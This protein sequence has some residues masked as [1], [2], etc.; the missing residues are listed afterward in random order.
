MTA[1]KPAGT[2][3]GLAVVGMAVC[4]GLPVLLSLGAAVTIAGTE[5]RSVALAVAGLIAVA[6]GVVRIRRQRSCTAAP[7]ADRTEDTGHADRD[8]TR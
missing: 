4:C 1:D 7:P 8:R 2:I 5:L 6:F 3:A